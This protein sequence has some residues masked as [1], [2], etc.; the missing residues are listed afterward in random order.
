MTLQSS[1][2]E[3]LTE[4]NLVGQD[5]TKIGRVADIYV[6]NTSRQPEWV[7]VNTGLF[8]TKESFVPLAQAT[9]QDGDI[10]VPYDKAT[11][12]DAPK[13]DV[14]GELNEAEEAELYRYYG[15]ADP[16]AGKVEADARNTATESAMTRSEEEMHAGTIKRPS[17]LVRLKKYVVTEHQQMT[18]PVQ[19]EEVRV[20]TEPITNENRGETEISEDEHAM[21]LNQEE[22]VVEKRVVPKE[23]VRLDKETVT[24][25]QTV[26]AELR[27]EKIDV[28][29]DPKKN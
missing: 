7:L 10:V 25:Q 9:E 23:Q 26:D 3:R 20:V 17:E 28:E 8:G 29:R 13:I 19:H 11:V 24:E 2:L 1:D 4:G 12:K 14:D 6:D 5:G 27:K 16:F 22:V 21:T 15:L 18:V